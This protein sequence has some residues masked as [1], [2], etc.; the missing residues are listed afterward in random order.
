MENVQAQVNLAAEIA[1]IVT[2]NAG[3]QAGVSNVNFTV[4]DV[5]AEFEIAVHLDSRKYR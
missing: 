1:S 2:I 3:I 5:S 4:A